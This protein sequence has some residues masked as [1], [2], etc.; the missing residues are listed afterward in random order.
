MAMAGELK[1][2]TA[3]CEYRFY[4]AVTSD[5][6]R[7]LEILQALQLYPKLYGHVFTTSDRSYYASCSSSTI[8]SLSRHHVT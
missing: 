3:F 1:A 8:K 7:P 4:A 2:I 6:K 5:V